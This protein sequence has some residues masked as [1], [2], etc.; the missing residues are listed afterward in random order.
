MQDP[1]NGQQ[2]QYPPY[3]P[4]PQTQLGAPPPSSSGDA[5]PPP[6][7]QTQL[8]AP[9][10]SA[11]GDAYPAYP[12]PSTQYPPYPQTSQPYPQA[13]QPYQQPPSYP[14]YGGGY[15][16]P[17]RKNQTTL[18]IILGVVAA[19]IIVGAIIAVAVSSNNKPNTASS[20]PPATQQA[21]G[22]PTQSGQQPTSVPT[23]SSSSSSSGAHNIGDVVTLDGWQV[24]VNSAKT[25]HGG[26][27]DTPEHAGD[28]Y[29]EIDASVTNQT[30]QNQT[31]SSLLSFTLKDSTGQKYD[32]SFVS[33]APSAP[34]G[35][36][37]NNG[38][39]RGTLVYEIP[40]TMKS[41]ELDF[42]PS[43]ESN[44]LAVWNITVS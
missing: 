28:I 2:S 13:S 21:S 33:D 5:Y 7:Q 22:A 36:V 40:P 10:P 37:Q 3:T 17:P 15:P 9:P 6:Y 39:L 24:V 31:F 42:S 30:G 43:L 12:Q 1:S 16:Q 20:N 35:N 4:Y 14:P 27:Y 11:S 29:L 44:D 41:F 23:Q 19:V 38:K 26:Q 8:G 25:S 32:Q 18:W 34:D